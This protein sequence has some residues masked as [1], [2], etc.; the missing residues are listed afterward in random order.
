M[1]K[2]KDNSKVKAA[3]RE[4]K[5]AAEKLAAKKEELREYNEHNAIGWKNLEER[6][7]RSEEEK[8]KAKGLVDEIKTLN[9]LS[10]VAGNAVS[11]AMDEVSAETKTAMNPQYAEAL[12]GI[13]DAIITLLDEFDKEDAIVKELREAGIQNLPTPLMNLNRENVCNILSGRNGGIGDVLNS[14]LEK[15][16]TERSL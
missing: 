11:T 4:V 3:E 5:K 6:L 10:I 13:K 2:V 1:Q 9:E 14:I 15:N 16:L 7:Y 8:T 12:D